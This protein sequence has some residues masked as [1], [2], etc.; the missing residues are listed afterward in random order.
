MIRSHF[1]GALAI[2]ALAAGPAF[3]DPPDA[4]APAK[5]LCSSLK[6]DNAGKRVAKSRDCI[7][8]STAS[9]LSQRASWL[10]T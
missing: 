2:A 8:D 10:R 6:K 4:T 1:A 9:P 3:A 7:A 5:P